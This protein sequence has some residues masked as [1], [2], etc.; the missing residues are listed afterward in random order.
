LENTE[1]L[2]ENTEETDLREAPP[3]KYKKMERLE[4]IVDVKD[5]FAEN[6]VEIRS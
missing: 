1:K 4:K 3:P 5:K 6:F 2:L